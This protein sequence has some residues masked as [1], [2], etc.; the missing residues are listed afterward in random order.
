MT[1]SNLKRK[2]L[3]LFLF[4]A[5]IVVF[6]FLH[7]WPFFTLFIGEFRTFNATMF[8]VWLI[9]LLGM[10]LLTGYSGQ[11]SLGHAALVLISAYLTAI[12]SQQYGF[13][14]WENMAGTYVP[15]SV[16]GTDLT[17]AFALIV[18]VLMVRPTGIFGRQI[19]RRV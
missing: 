6:P 11:I 14:L 1:T 9:I 7:D 19:Q 5:L 2:A 3:W 10:N 12:F 15:S 17:I 4:G 18:L 8:G 16:G 13:P